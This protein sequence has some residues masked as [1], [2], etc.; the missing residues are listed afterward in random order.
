MQH[1]SLNIRTDL[2]N[3]NFSDFDKISVDNDQSFLLTP[4]DLNSK[5]YSFGDLTPDYNWEYFC[6]ELEYE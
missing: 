5:F 4:Y 6:N 2:H 3:I 1:T